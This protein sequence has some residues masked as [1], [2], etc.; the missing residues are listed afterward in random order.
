MQYFVG[1][2]LST[3]LEDIDA[4]WDTDFWRSFNPMRLVNDNVYKNGGRG[5]DNDEEECG[6]RE[7]GDEEEANRSYGDEDGVR[8]SNKVGREE[9]EKDDEGEEVENRDRRS[10]YRQDH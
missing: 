8:G 1:T 7:V 6:S 4:E 5:F 3:T 2:R 10:K 9:E